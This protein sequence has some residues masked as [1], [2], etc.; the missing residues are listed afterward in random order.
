MIVIVGGRGHGMAEFIDTFDVFNNVIDNYHLLINEHNKFLDYTM[1]NIETFKNSIVIVEEV[2][3]G[4]VPLET[5][6]RHKRDELGRVYQF[7]CQEAQIVVRIWYGI[8]IFIKGSKIDFNQ[9]IER[10]RSN[11]EKKIY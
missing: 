4:I 11:Y 7:L 9:E 2:G 8:P 10:I 5:K 3:L 6:L 1:S